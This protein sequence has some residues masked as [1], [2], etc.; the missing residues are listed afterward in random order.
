MVLSNECTEFIPARSVSP[1][2]R[3]ELAK[4]RRYHPN[5]GGITRGG[6]A[7]HFPMTI[8]AL[9]GLGASEAEVR[10]FMREWPRS[11]AP[12]ERVEGPE[13]RESG[14]GLVDRGV[15]TA[16]SWPSFLGRSEQLLE[17]R[18]V[19]ETELAGPSGLATVTKALDVMRDGLPMG[20]FHPLIRLSFAL[21][22]GDHG[23]VA[24]AL[25]YMAIR[26]FDLYRGA[27][28]RPPAG[29]GEPRSAESV[30][31][32]MPEVDERCQYVLDFAGGSIRVCEEL[33]A[34]PA[35]HA[36]A[37]PPGLVF[38]S[39]TLPACMREIASLAVRLYLHSP[40]LTTLHAVTALQG[41]AEVTERLG[42]TDPE[43]FADLWARY[44]VWLT[45]LW[46]EKGRPDLP[47]AAAR[48][49]GEDWAEL[50]ARA[51]AIPEVHLIKMAY[52]CRWLDQTFGPNPLYA[53]PVVAMLRERQTRR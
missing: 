43:L 25:A 47:A 32:S 28:P 53:M 2:V 12:L 4:D 10:A 33:C 44:W 27:L 9:S 5:L 50:A 49:P 18:R 6:L 48:G 13:G 16:A 35:L 8:L 17:L 29:P 3:D 19:F 52:S 7:N 51:R 42:A 21:G 30:W 23:L 34:E 14:L 31:R 45:A 26:H 24:D 15:V 39:A 46:L 20:L 37:L 22:H 36:A 11:R 1:L 41:L 38:S 40:A